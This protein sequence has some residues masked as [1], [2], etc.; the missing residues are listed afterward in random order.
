[1]HK[2]WSETVAELSIKNAGRVPE[3]SHAARG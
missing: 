3:Q 1:M 2:T